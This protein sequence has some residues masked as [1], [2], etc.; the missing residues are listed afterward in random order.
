MYTISFYIFWYIHSIW[1]ICWVN[2]LKLV[3]SV[4]MFQILV[5]ADRLDARQGAIFACHSEEVNN[6]LY[7]QSLSPMYYLQSEA[8]HVQLNIPTID[9]H[10]S[11]VQIRFKFI[12]RC[13]IPTHRNNRSHVLCTA[14]VTTQ[15]NIKLFG[16]EI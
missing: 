12:F 16:L 9:F 4:A 13:K 6:I 14:P 15:I 10:D 7:T 8:L 11:S 5:H 2:G 1:W 3:Y